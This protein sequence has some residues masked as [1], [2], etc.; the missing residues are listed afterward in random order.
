MNHVFC[1]M[2]IAHGHL[3]LAHADVRASESYKLARAFNC[4]KSIEKDRQITDR[5]GQNLAEC[6]LAGPSRFIPVGPSLGMLEVSPQRV[7]R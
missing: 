7:K 2:A 6:H 4:F 1:F 3:R 5:R